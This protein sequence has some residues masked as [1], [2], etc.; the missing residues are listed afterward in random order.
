MKNMNKKLGIFA[1]AMLVFVLM[2]S[3]LALPAMAQGGDNYSVY[4][5]VSFDDEN[6]TCDVT[7]TIVDTNVTMA[8]TCDETTGYVFELLNIDGLWDFGDEVNITATYND[9]GTD[10]TASKIV[11]IT[12]NAEHRLRVDL[13]LSAEVADDEPVTD[14]TMI[15]LIIIAVVVA[16]VVVA[17]VMTRGKKE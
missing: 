10:V 12:E 13:D 16:I 1:S 4:G 3:A 15:L 8:T 2:F 7:L 11:E 9:N 14:W 5:V 17:L 6:V